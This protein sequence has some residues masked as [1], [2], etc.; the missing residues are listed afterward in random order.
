MLAPGEASLRA[1]ESEAWVAVSARL[2]PDEAEALATAHRVRDEDR[3]LEVPFETVHEYLFLLRSGARATATIGSRATLVLAAAVSDFYVPESELAEH[4]IQSRG[5]ASGLDIHLHGVPKVLGHVTR[6]WAPHAFVVSFKLETDP[7]LLV[8]KATQARERYGVHAVV[9]N[10]LQH[11]YSRVLVLPRSGPG[12]ELH[13]PAGEGRVVEDALVA[14]LVE[15]HGNHIEAE[16]E[17]DVSRASPPPSVGSGA[18]G[19]GR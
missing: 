14:R 3:L 12:E 18:A 9:A 15:L 17:A 19:G 10:M 11:R 1:A 4:K 13:R 16:A 7:K 6:T 5:G 8:H 2:S